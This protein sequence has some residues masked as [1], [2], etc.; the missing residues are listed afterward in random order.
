MDVFRAQKLSERRGGR[1]RLPV[2]NKPDGFCGRETILNVCGREGQHSFLLPFS[3]MGPD[4]KFCVR[5]I[6]QRGQAVEH[7]KARD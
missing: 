2:P 4:L 6:P 3:R 5:G 1:P 7:A